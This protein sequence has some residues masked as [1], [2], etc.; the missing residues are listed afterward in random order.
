MFKNII[1]SKNFKFL[2][3][4]SSLILGIVMFILLLGEKQLH[5]NT[6][7]YQG[8]ETLNKATLISKDGKRMDVTL[9]YVYKDDDIDH[10]D[11]ELDVSSIKNTKN[12]AIG[13]QIK[14]S[15][16]TI[17]Y[18]NNK[19]FYRMT[20]PKKYIPKSGGSAAYYIIDMPIYEKADKLIIHIMPSFNIDF[21]ILINPID[22]GFRNDFF[23]NLIKNDIG[24][25]LCVLSF[26]S[27]AILS[28]FIAFF[29]RSNENLSLK[30]FTTGVA[31]IVFS[32][33]YATQYKTVLYLLSNN[34]GLLYFLQYITV[35]SI[36]YFYI[37]IMQRD[38]RGVFLKL[39][40]ISKH[41]VAVIYLVRLV[42]TLTGVIEFK[43]LY[44]L[45]CVITIYLN[46]LILSSFIFTK[47]QDKKVRGE[48]F[49]YSSI[50]IVLII[51]FY[52]SYILGDSQ[53]FS[54]ILFITAMLYF[55][56][57]LYTSS[58]LYIEM[59]KE[60]A[61]MSV[62]E[63]LLLLDTLT[64]V[65]SRYAFEKRIQQLRKDNISVT[66][67]TA[68]VNDLKKINDQLGHKAGDVVI[69][70]TAK[71]LQNIFAED[72]VYRTGGDEYVVISERKIDE[73][74]LNNIDRHIH[75]DYISDSFDILFSIGVAYFDHNNN[76]TIDEVI[77]KSDKK[78]YEDKKRL[79]LG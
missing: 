24:G 46:V 67:I 14:Y 36:F 59:V 35:S 37:S 55:L 42:L 7:D 58:R 53:L 28:M 45:D 79:K 40:V 63:D 26:F 68:D 6:F 52:L 13:I 41:L 65:N 9:P 49:I 72:E 31:S 34:R 30:V 71:K 69:K 17:S 70:A 44:K 15:N 8:L 25:I 73:D 39:F 1:Y 27:I 32:I 23:I 76:A 51:S 48:G 2:Y 3:Y 50:I 61:N 33:Y 10:L 38:T 21:G 54:T 20:I 47:S 66:I 60:N 56:T 22:V 4:F 74:F 12:K 62:Y 5:N 64:N 57:Q 43:Q 16:F 78:M 11:V 18:N 19:E 77:K 75:I 29:S